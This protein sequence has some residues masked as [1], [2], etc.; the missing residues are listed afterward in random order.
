MSAA[1][2]KARA[3]LSRF[4]AWTVS[5]GK[6]A[7]S[8]SVTGRKQSSAA[9]L[10]AA[11]AQLKREAKG[12]DKIPQDK[13]VYVFVEAEAKSTSAKQPKGSFY[14]SKVGKKTNSSRKTIRQER[15]FC[16]LKFL[17]FEL[18]AHD[19]FYYFICNRTGPSEES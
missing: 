16:I 9:Q 2:D 17:S 12:D 5:A 8:V 11:T 18:T 1:Q 6:S 19:F 3:A 13:R 4:K 15:C 10:I 7:T 14:Y